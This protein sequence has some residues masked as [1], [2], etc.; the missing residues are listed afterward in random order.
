MF[1]TFSPVR[2]NEPL[3]A[4]R[5]GDSLIL[6]GVVCDY[7]D[8]PEGG[9]ADG[10]PSPWILGPVLRREGRLRLTLILP[11]GSDAPAETLF[12]APL[13]DPS[14]GPLPLPPFAAILPETV[15]E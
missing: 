9:S 6:N 7:S 3:A 2:M 5:Q 11:H 8:L 15:S 12:P 10:H 14:D 4:E 1:I 13:D